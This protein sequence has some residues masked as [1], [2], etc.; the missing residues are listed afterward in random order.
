MLEPQRPCAT[1]RQGSRRGRTGPGQPTAA[2]W[3]FTSASHRAPNLTRNSQAL[4]ALLADVAEYGWGRDE[5]YMHD[6][7]D[8]LGGSQVVYLFECPRCGATDPMGPRLESPAPLLQRGRS[9]SD[10]DPAASAPFR[11][12]R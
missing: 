2:T 11:A 9:S 1:E 12:K 7:I 10:A 6:F 4:D 3:G 8:G 5:Q